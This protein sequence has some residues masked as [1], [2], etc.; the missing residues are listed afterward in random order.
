MATVPPP[1]L[2]RRPASP[3]P[4]GRREAA[5]ADPGTRFLICRGTSHLVRDDP[6]ASIAFLGAGE[7]DLDAVDPSRLLLLGWFG[8]R[9][10]LMVDLPT[11]LLL[12]PPGTSYEELRPLLPR[13]SA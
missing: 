5:R 9:R 1:G 6:Q 8:G 2:Q 10:C 11:D 13:Q 4:P 7:L 12:S 3:H